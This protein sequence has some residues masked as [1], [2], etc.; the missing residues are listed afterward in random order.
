MS[1]RRNRGYPG[2][3]REVDSCSESE[4]GDEVYDEDEDEQTE[5][6]EQGEIRAPGRARTTE[7]ETQNRIDNFFRRFMDDTT[8]PVGRR[9]AEE[10]EAQRRARR[11]ARLRGSPSERQPTSHQDLNVEAIS[12]SAPGARRRIEEIEIRRQV[13]DGELVPAASEYQ[14]IWLRILELARPFV[15]PLPVEIYGDVMHRIR[16][17]APPAVWQ[18]IRELDEQLERRTRARDRARG[19]ASPAPPPRLGVDPNE[20]AMRGLLGAVAAARDRNLAADERTTRSAPP[21]P[22]L[23]DA[24]D[25]TWFRAPAMQHRIA[26]QALQSLNDE[27]AEEAR[28]RGAPA[29]APWEQMEDVPTEVRERAG[30]RYGA[31]MQM[32]VDEVGALQGR[33][34]GA[35]G[36]PMAV[37]EEALRSTNVMIERLAAE[38]RLDEAASPTSGPE[39]DVVSITAAG[40]STAATHGTGED[41]EPGEQEADDTDDM[42]IDSRETRPRPPPQATVEEDPDFQLGPRRSTASLRRAFHWDAFEMQERPKWAKICHKRDHEFNCEH[43]DDAKSLSA[44]VLRRG[45]EFTP[46]A[47]AEDL[48]NET[49]TFLVSFQG[50]GHHNAVILEKPGAGVGAKCGCRDFPDASLGCRKAESREKCLFCDRRNLRQRFLRESASKVESQC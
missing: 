16:A 40:T 44:D 32:I 8:T 48:E 31:E 18:Q 3:I 22:Q 5:D 29:P 12:S 46:W 17:A 49:A 24:S 34:P 10:L 45:G 23:E 38:A 28:A 20:I 36:H 7:D 1:G 14:D 25:E 39:T 19:S 50:C 41:S 33:R 11:L 37:R 27:A 43:T 2:L 21:T 30:A 26:A 15:R 9:R 42:N 47:T 13:R 6:L 35:L 4:G